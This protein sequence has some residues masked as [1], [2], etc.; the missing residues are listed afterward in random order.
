MKQKPYLL[1]KLVL[2]YSTLSFSQVNFPI[3][4]NRET[5]RQRFINGI[6]ANDI[7]DMDCVNNPAISSCDYTIIDPLPGTNNDTERIQSA[8]NNATIGRTIIFKTGT[9][10]FRNIAIRPNIR[11]KVQKN[12]IFIPFIQDFDVNTKNLTM[13]TLGSSSKGNISTENISVSAFTNKLEDRFT[14]DFTNLDVNS[15]GVVAFSVG[16]A[17]NFRLAN[18]NIEDNYTRLQCVSL[19]PQGTRIKESFG[20]L[21][22]YSGL[23]YNTFTGMPTNGIIEHANVNKAAFG[24]G[25]V[26]GQVGSNIYF[27]ELS[28]DGGATLRLESGSF[29]IAHA[30]PSVKEQIFFE[31]IYGEKISSTNGH[32]AVM[33]SPH[34]VQNKDVHFKDITATGSAVGIRVSRGFLTPDELADPNITSIGKGK[35]TEVT[36][37][38]F[39]DIKAG[40]NAQLKRNQH[41]RIVE[42][43][44]RSLF[45]PPLDGTGSNQTGD[46]ESFRGPSVAAITYFANPPSGFTSGEDGYYDVDFDFDSASKNRLIDRRNS[47]NNPNPTADG[48]LNSSTAARPNCSNQTLSNIDIEQTTNQFSINNNGNSINITTSN[49]NTF[50]NIYTISGILVK[51]LNFAKNSEDINV[52]DLSSGIYIFEITIDG[53]KSVRKIHI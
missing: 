42:C 52:F 29:S 41:F 25:L 45:T 5:Y 2:L 8:I 32:T 23:I 53:K 38:G 18:F 7:I 13:F 31:G 19:T 27:Y 14:F 22:Q 17:N 48:I 20:D 4:E 21:G 46:N 10:R 37:E 35:F 1:L 34:S 39:A 15:K 33:V 9:Y 28:G 44:L 11:I 51:S 50:V 26:Q 30:L 49:K 12:V 43:A 3:E 40:N 16:R 6:P 36:F 47:F 24:Y